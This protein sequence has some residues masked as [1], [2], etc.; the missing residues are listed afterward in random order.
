VIFI[1]SMAINF[2]D[3]FASPIIGFCFVVIL[4]LFVACVAL[5]IYYCF[6]SASASNENRAFLSTTVAGL[7]L[8]VASGVLGTPAQVPGNTT[9]TAASAAALSA[10]RIL[11][12]SNRKAVP[13]TAPAPSQEGA[14]TISDAARI[15][16]R[17]LYT[18]TYLICGIGCLVVYFLIKTPRN[19]DLVKTVGITTIGFF[20]SL[21]KRV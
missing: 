17:N 10:S 4:L 20:I 11:L 12:Q 5:G 18:W 8:S 7:V 19:D 15:A 13:K 1:P 14:L 9:D 3:L 6:R 2:G 21:I 16:I